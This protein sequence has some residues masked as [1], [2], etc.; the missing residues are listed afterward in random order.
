MCSPRWFVPICQRRIFGIRDRFLIW[1]VTIRHFPFGCESRWS[2]SK[3]GHLSWT[4]FFP[5][6]SAADEL[7]VIRHTSELCYSPL[8][9]VALTC[10]VLS[11][12]LFS[13]VMLW[14]VVGW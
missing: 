3:T 6:P 12:L 14:P 8:C 11:A 2:S 9:C 10:V 1:K 5:K 13:C 7:C 4:W